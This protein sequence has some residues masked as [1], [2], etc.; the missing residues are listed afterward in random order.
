MVRSKGSVDARSVND[1]KTVPLV[2][3]GLLGRDFRARGDR[4]IACE[5][6][7]NRGLSCRIL[8]GKNDL[9]F[10]GFLTSVITV[11]ACV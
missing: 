4:I 7:N 11:D 5:H 1:L 9:D 6:L 8:T 2:G 10:V 3:V